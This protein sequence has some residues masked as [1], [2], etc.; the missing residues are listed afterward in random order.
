MTAG[1]GG[2]ALVVGVIFRW[3]AWPDWRMMLAG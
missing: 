2:V 3:L 1:M